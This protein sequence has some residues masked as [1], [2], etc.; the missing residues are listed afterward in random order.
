[1]SIIRL[2]LITVTKD[3][4]A[5]LAR[6]LASAAAL[7]AVG[8]EHLVVDGGSDPAAT[9]G[10]VAQA[11]EGV[12]VIA[13]P[14]QGIADAFNAGIAAARGEWL[15]FL[16]GGD[17][18]HEALD[19]SWLFA[20]LAGTRAQV[21]TGAVQYDGD[22]VL[23]PL[24]PLAGQWP[25]LS[26]WLAHPATLIRRD[27]LVATGGFDRR[28]Q[29]AMDYDLWHRLLKDATVDVISVPFA[30]FDVTGISQRPEKH[31]LVCREEA[32]VLLNHWGTLSGAVL[33]TVGI[34]TRR[35]IWAVWHW[36][37]FENDRKHG[38]D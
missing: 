31:A 13:R 38:R 23:R 2:S 3:D 15:W 11:G 24:P 28:C 19:S 21:I 37:P 34:F 10:I 6:T 30:R 4:A 17:A 27:K 29:I 14:P 33:R 9:D 25:M 7:R 12:T 26:C 18:V 36:R 5:G 8:A 16:N 1:M 22:A 20:L 35:M 32:S